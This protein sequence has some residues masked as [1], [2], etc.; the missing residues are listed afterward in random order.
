MYHIKWAN[1]APKILGILCKIHR[2]PR[3]EERH[4]EISVLRDEIWK[5]HMSKTRTAPRLEA[6]K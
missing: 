2:K 6:K 5:S 1:Q 4:K 3:E